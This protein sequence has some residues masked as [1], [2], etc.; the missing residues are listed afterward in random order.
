MLDEIEKVI[1]PLTSYQ[2]TAIGIR[3]Q[4]AHAVRKGCNDFLD[5]ARATYEESNSDV[6]DLVGEY[7][8][9]F[10]LPI[11]L[12]F[13]SGIGFYLTLSTDDFDALEQIPVEFINIV[14]KGKSIHFSTITLASCS[15]TN[16]TNFTIR[17]A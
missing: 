6:T 7:T 14:R 3:H 5:V 15:S 12:Q 11:K 8:Q 16:Y 4:K 1:D 10:Q 2:K 17:L 13:T 9:M